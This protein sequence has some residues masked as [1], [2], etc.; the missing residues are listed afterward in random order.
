[1][2]EDFF[3]LF[4]FEIDDKELVTFTKKLN[5][6]KSMVMSVSKVM[7][8]GAVAIG[9]FVTAMAKNTESLGDFA[10]LEQMSVEAV[11]ELGY[12][13]SMTGSN[14]EAVKASIGGLN[15][16]MGDAAL[17]FG[18]G[19]QAFEHYGLSAKHADGTLKSTDEMLG[20]I[21]G[22]MERLSRQEQISMAEKL[23]LDRSLIPMLTMGRDKMREMR[24][25]AAAFGRMTE[26]DTK[27][28]TE[29]MIS[30]RQTLSIVQNLG[31][32]IAVR[33]MPGMTKM[34][35]GFRKW[36]LANR[37][38]IQSR[39]EKFVKLFNIALSFTWDWIMRL[40][41]KFIDLVSWLTSTKTGVVLLTAAFAALVKVAAYKAFTPVIEGVKML[42]K[43]FTLASLQATLMT[44]AIGLLIIAVGLLID[45]F[46]N[47]KEGNESVI[48]DL[49]K[50][51]PALLDIINTMEEGV[52][53]FI[54]FWMEQ[55]E[56]LKGPLLE[57]GGAIWEMAKSIVSFLWPIVKMALKGIVFLL[58][59]IIPY[60]ISAAKMF[61][62]FFVGMWKIIITVLTEI[63][64]FVGWVY[65]W[66]GESLS[67]AFDEA[68]EAVSFL[69]EA[70]IDKF[71]S[72]KDTAVAIVMFIA[73]TIGNIVEFISDGINSVIDWVLGVIDRA[74]QRVMGFIDTVTGA[75]RKVGELL[76]LTD[77]SGEI[78]VNV[79]GGAASASPTVA[80]AV[81]QAP[82]LQGPEASTPPRMGGPG[83]VPTSPLGRGNLSQ[84][85]NTTNTTNTT[86]QAINIQ[87]PDPARAG[88]SVREELDK[89]NR[90]TIR[91]LQSAKAY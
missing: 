72:W 77:K 33:L 47:F 49:C 46:V 7:S 82:A 86:V 8:A 58:A 9:G 75:I 23:G 12:A 45:D 42:A 2:I 88:E 26:K 76:G 29:Y 83:G 52:G 74:K 50:E 20:D 69:I 27:T 55:W 89:A 54:D 51:F 65:D 25:E 66:I 61:I 37:A 67:A 15:R 40:G 90:Q 16:V 18:R 35:D 39:V 85:S 4:G 34:M 31:R 10:H 53:A 32:S 6:A 22:K 38:L 87:S 3:A 68:R 28:S 17:G 91:N 14:M 30:L 79:S 64:R 13:A 71:L 24:E 5:D 11:S 41:G 84:V 36:L 19:A 43:A 63:A 48:G 70:I 56:E 73:E 80:D 62:G 44:V 57:L 1:M 21:A 60:A 78:K 81:A 59:L